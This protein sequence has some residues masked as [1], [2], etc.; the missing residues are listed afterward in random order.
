M[1]KKNGF[2]AD[3]AE[4]VCE[5][6]FGGEDAYKRLGDVMSEIEI[7]IEEAINSV[8]YLDCNYWKP[9]PIGEEEGR[10]ILEEI[11]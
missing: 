5:A 1:S 3:T 9:E 7:F 2:I 10:K 11:E 4:K 8:H 6:L